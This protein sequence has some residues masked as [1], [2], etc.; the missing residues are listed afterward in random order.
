[1]MVWPFPPGLQQ[2]FFL[3]LR[4][5]HFD[6]HPAS[7]MQCGH[8]SERLS[9]LRTN[10]MLADQLKFLAEQEARR[11]HSSHCSRQSEQGETDYRPRA[12]SPN[13]AGPSA[14]YVG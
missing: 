14:R 1:M 2:G 7:S 10:H 13:A 11:P 4:S 5:H 6:S 3:V 8:T 12:P 9:T